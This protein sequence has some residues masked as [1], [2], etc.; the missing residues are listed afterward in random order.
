VVYPN[1]T[2]GVFV[3]E[4]T[5][6]REGASILITDMAGKTIVTRTIDHGAV[7]TATFDLSA[8]ARGIYMVMV[9]DGNYTYR[10]KVVVQ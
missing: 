5:E 6:I 4:L 10:T 1:P 9:K 2:T 8:L 7:P 3:L